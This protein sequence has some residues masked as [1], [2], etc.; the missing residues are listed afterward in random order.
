M[1][2]YCARPAFT[3]A[4]AHGIVLPNRERYSVM[5]PSGQKQP[6]VSG[7]PQVVLSVSSTRKYALIDWRKRLIDGVVT[8]KSAR[9]ELVLYMDRCNR[10]I[11]RFQ[12]QRR[13]DLY[14]LCALFTWSAQ[15]SSMVLSS[16]SGRTFSSLINLKKCSLGLYS[17]RLTAKALAMKPAFR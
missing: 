4:Q 1:S 7:L 12:L 10:V 16:L 5:H 3:T 6:P 11:V 15:N 9:P 14:H 17:A 2:C 13:L 8:S